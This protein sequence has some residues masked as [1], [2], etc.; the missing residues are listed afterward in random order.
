[1]ATEKFEASK[2]TPAGGLGAAPV[3]AV[4]PRCGASEPSVRTVP[5]ACAA[6]DSPGSGLSDR[7]AK[8]PGVESRFDSSLHFLEG[9]ALT[10]VCA[11]LAQHGVQDDK[12]LFTIGGAVLAVLLF[13]GTLWVVRGEA[14]ERATVAAGRPRAEELW[15]PAHHCASCES[16]FYPTGSPWAGPL[17]T[18]QFRKYVWTEAGFT[19]Q[20]DE[21]LKQVEL[22][23][24][25]PT[26]P[27]APGG[28]H[29][30]A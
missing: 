30:H 4:C 18:D 9:M 20:L 25:T 13:V 29:G 17:T 16:V 26:G 11:G 8:A 27:T 10:V 19:K 6:P 28:A 23:P 2:E 1:M 12:P 14:R 21:K 3:M 5:D 15:N 24:R 7:L 22:P